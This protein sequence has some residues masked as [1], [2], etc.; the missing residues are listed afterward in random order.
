MFSL[1]GKT[2]V[3]MGIANKRSIGFGVAKVLDQ[4]GAK[5]VFTYRKDRSRKELEKLLDQLNQDEPKMYQIDVQKDDDVINGFAKIGEEVGQIDG[6]YHSIA[7]ANV[8]ELRGRF[9]ETS[10]DGFLLAQDI[11]SFSLTIVAREAS[12]I[13]KDG[14]S[15]VATTY[16]G[17]EYAIPSYNVMGIAKASLEACVKYL[18]LDLGQDNI[19]VNAISAGP[20]RTLSAKGVGNFNSILKEI[21]QR[22]PLQRNVDQE[23]VG[24]TAAFLLS[25]L[26]SGVTGE[27]IHVDAGFHATK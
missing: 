14:G 18:A 2:Y 12:K 27:N 19:R 15:I 26:A 10:R 11:S 1:E 21:E 17:G 22:S 23:E 9:S 24:K 4:L 13:M 16:I 8:E 5:L 25:D 20:I 7:F 3:I 6:V